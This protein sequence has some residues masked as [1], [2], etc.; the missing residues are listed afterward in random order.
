MSGVK[1]GDTA[2]T[3]IRCLIRQKAMFSLRKGKRRS[4]AKMK[5]AYNSYKEFL[6]IPGALH[7]KRVNS[8]V[9]KKKAQSHLPLDQYFL[10]K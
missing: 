7:R 9:Q 1:H 8:D 2:F 5:V 6:D 4:K 3:C 10:N